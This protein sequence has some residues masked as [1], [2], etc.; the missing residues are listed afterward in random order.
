VIPV[1]STLVVIDLQPVFQLSNSPWCTPGFDSVVSG[2][3]AAS[4]LFDTVLATRFVLPE[5][6]EGSWTEYYRLWSE[7][8]SPEFEHSF[9]LVKEIAELGCEVVSR[10]TFSKWCDA[11]AEHVSGSMTLVGVAT[12]CCVLATALSAVDAGC[13]VSIITDLCRGSTSELHDSALRTLSSFAP[14]IHLLDSSE[15]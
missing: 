4:A 5:Q 9:D 13:S 7:V 15:L 14:Q 1:G 10:P 6:P 12:E 8:R 11:L 2:I 3:V